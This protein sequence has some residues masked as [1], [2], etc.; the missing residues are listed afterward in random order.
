MDAGKRDA[1]AR[2]QGFSGCEDE[3]KEPDFEDMAGKAEGRLVCVCVSACVRVLGG[4]AEGLRS[5]F[6]YSSK[7]A[8]STVSPA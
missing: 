4:K 1:V 3:A 5:V 2:L 6:I 7:S 8:P